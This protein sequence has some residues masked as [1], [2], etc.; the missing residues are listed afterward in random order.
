MFIQSIQRNPFLNYQE[1]FQLFEKKFV[2]VSRKKK[3]RQLFCEGHV[4]IS[5]SG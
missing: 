3:I 1:I 2:F 5:S 4:N